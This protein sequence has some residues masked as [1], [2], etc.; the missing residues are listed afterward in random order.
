ME[1]EVW[2]D[3]PE[4]KGFYQISNLGNIR[5][6]CRHGVHQKID[7]PTI[8]K[9]FPK[10]KI[11]YL[12]VTLS[13]K[14]KLVHRI[15]LETFMG[16]SDL[17][18]NHKNGVKTDNRLENLEWISRKENIQHAVKN[19]LTSIGEKHYLTHLTNA[20]AVLIKKLKGKFFQKTIADLFDVSRETISSIWNNHNWKHVCAVGER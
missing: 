14:Q 16:K 6:F 8:L 5:S 2:K 3:I 17:E 9:T 15:V 7:K 13:G 19:G 10:R 4:Y 18:C 12:A 1:L 20:D 11:G